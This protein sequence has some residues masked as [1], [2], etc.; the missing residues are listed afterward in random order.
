MS[1]L[2]ELIKAQ[3]YTTAEFAEQ[4]GVS[5]RTLDMYVSGARDFTNTPVWLAVKV[6]DALEID[7]HDIID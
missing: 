4:A 1:K 5:K 3:G 6:A 2:K 7:I